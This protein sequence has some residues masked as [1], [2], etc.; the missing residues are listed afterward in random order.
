MFRSISI[1][2]L[3]AAVIYGVVFIHSTGLLGCESAV[4]NWFQSQ[5]RFGVPCFVVAWAYSC[6]KLADDVLCGM[7]YD[8]NEYVRPAVLLVSVIICAVSIQHN[9]I[10][11]LLLGGKQ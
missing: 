7:F 6:R 11:L 5:F 2:I 1:D 3:K 10:S 9:T 4:S 8:L